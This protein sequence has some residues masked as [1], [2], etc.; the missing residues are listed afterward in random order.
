MPRSSRLIITARIR[1]EMK[2]VLIDAASEAP[3]GREQQ[4]GEGI[5]KGGR[6]GSAQLV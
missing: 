4:F 1:L 5:A 3:I 2:D 6:P